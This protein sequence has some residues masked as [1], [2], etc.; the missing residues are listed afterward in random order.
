MSPCDT[1][2][3][4]ERPSDRKDG[5]RRSGVGGLVGSSTGG[6]YCKV[7]ATSL[8]IRANDFAPVAVEVG[9][10]LVRFDK[11]TIEI[12]SRNVPPN[13]TLFRSPRLL[14]ARNDN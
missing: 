9:R 13:I 6:E 5:K 8:S 14:L 3:A 11:Q 12:Y 2:D 4:L 10:R 7:L 1:N